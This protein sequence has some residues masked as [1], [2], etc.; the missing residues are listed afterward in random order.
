MGHLIDGI[1]KN[2]DVATSDDSGKFKRE[3]SKFDAIISSDHPEF[4]PESNRYHLYVSYACPWAHRTLITRKLKKLEKHISFN[5]V[6]PDMLENSWTFRT[7]F[8]GATGDDLYDLQFLHQ[9]YKKSESKVSTKV[10]VPVLWDKKLEKVVNNES[11]QILRILNSSFNELEGVNKELDLYPSHL[12]G[13]IDEVNNIVYE[14]INNGVYKTGFAKNQEAYNEA[15]KELFSSLDSL[16]SRLEGNNFLVS[17][18]LTEAD[19]R[20]M[21]TLL[22]FDIVYYTHFKCNQ[23]KIS[24]YKNLHRYSQQ[25]YSEY[26][27]INQTTHF[28]H[29]KRH[30]YYSHDFI[31]PHRI[32]PR[33]PKNLFLKD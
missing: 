22:R 5:V 9:L 4:Q 18:Q 23:K 33:G 19:I 1:W 8:S 13:E 25:L 28:D 21:V 6:H 17:D 31:N 11:S 30:Y 29:I 2:D 26:E 27:A 32:V 15:F 14:P 10:T 12:R 7:D 20:L 16:E 3:K 24:E